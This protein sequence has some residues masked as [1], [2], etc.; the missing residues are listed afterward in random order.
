MTLVA[1]GVDPANGDYYYAEYG[2][3]QG[4]SVDNVIDLYAL[5][6]TDGTSAQVAI[7]DLSGLGLIKNAATNGFGNGDLAFDQSG[8]CSFLRVPTLPMGDIQ[9]VLS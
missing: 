9:T 5:D 1:G 4:S 3:S 8:D 6:P 7:L 2:R